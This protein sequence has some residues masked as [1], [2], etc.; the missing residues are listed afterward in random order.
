MPVGVDPSAE[1]IG[2][3]IQAAWIDLGVL[4]VV[5]IVLSVAT[6]GSHAGVS[7]T[8]VNGTVIHSGGGAASLNGPWTFIFFG[9]SLLYYF[10]LEA[11]FGQTI[12]KRIM[13]LKVV[14]ADGL[15]P[16]ATAI[17]LRTL[18]RVIDILPAFYLVGWIAVKRSRQPRQRLGDRLANTTVVAV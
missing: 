9:L 4:F 8:N 16:R 14:T 15:A 1:I 6:G 11:I 2:K 3:R 17:V 13:R 5:F 12:G 7:T 18:G 10:A